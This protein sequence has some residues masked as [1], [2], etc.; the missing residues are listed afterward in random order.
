[1]SLDQLASLLLACSL[2]NYAILL[3]WFAVFSLR[4]EQ[5]YRLHSRWFRLTP[6][7]FDALHYGAMALHK[8]GVLLLNLVPWLALRLLA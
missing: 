8:I 7:Q 2:L 6:E 1:M 3:V 5:L 4:H